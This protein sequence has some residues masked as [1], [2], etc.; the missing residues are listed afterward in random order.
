MKFVR[1]L[2]LLAMTG[3]VPGL[4]LQSVGQQEIDPEPL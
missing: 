4:V 1:F 2:V 3:P